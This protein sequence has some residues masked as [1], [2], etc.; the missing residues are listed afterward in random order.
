MCHTMIVGAATVV[1]ALLVIAG[2]ACVVDSPPEDVHAASAWRSLWQH[3]KHIAAEPISRRHLAVSRASPNSC[4]R[5]KMLRL[6]H[7]SKGAAR[8]L[9]RR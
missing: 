6:D 4:A 1:I 7:S 9:L 2:I 5:R 3:P 8:P